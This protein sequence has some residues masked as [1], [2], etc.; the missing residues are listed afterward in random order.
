MSGRSAGRATSYLRI[1]GTNLRW[2]ALC[3]TAWEIVFTGRVPVEY[4]TPPIVEEVRSV[5]DKMVEIVKEWFMNQGNALYVG[6]DAIEYSVKLGEGGGYVT[7]VSRP[8]LYVLWDAHGRPINL[9]VEVTARGSAYVPEE[10]LAA[11]MLGLY[12]R[13]LRPTFALLVRFEAAEARAWVGVLPLSTAL[14]ER[15]KRLMLSGTKRRPTMNLCYNCDL[16]AV[17]PSPLV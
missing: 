6:E 3:Q 16:R 4:S 1:W 14:L 12:V 5:H 9:V 2:A 7:I 17:C 13:N 11:E 15:L 8:D 10:W